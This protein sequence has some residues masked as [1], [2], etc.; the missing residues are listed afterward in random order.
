[1]KQV[2]QDNVQYVSLNRCIRLS[3]I[4]TQGQVFFLFLEENCFWGWCHLI[5][6][7]VDVTVSAGQALVLRDGLGGT[8]GL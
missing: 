7:S 2:L 5:T 8:A 4:A 1:M 6:L 3:K